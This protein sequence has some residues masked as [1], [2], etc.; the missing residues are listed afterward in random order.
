[1]RPRFVLFGLLA[2]LVVAFIVLSFG[3]GLI[4]DLLW[5]D[6]L[7]YRDVFTTTILAQLA[8]FGVVWLIAFIA[9]GLSAVIAL[10]LSREHRRNRGT[11]T[12]GRH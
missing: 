9:I 4:V 2:A 10:H 11:A 6:S 3:D 12:T 7:G 5:F 1:M 8:I